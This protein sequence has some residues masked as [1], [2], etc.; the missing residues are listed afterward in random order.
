MDE[1]ATL[2]EKPDMKTRAVNEI[3]DW[4]EI[5]VFSATFVILLFTFIARLTV[6]IGPSMQDTLFEGDYL[7]VSNL[8]YEPKQGDIVVC[9]NLSSGYTEPIVKR[10]IATEGQTVDI[11]FDTWTVTV[12]GVVLDES[13]YRKLTDDQ[14]Y[15]SDWSYP[16]I[17]PEGCIFVMGDNRNHS[18][19]SRFAS[20]GPMD[21]RCIV[22]RAIA[23]ILPLSDFTIY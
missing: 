17:V 14:R 6:V 10:V 11:D 8:F 22:G 18:V 15:T 3:Y 12:D 9:Q 23:L 1:N 21:T 5:F 4:A 19:D 7:V 13:A 16:I 20:I 2:L